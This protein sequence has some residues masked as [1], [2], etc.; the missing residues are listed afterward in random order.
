MPLWHWLNE[1]T[2]KYCIGKWWKV[3]GL[4]FLK[5]KNCWIQYK[6]RE[7]LQCL[8]GAKGR[9]LSENLIHPIPWMH[10]I[11][12]YVQSLI[13]IKK[14]KNRTN[15]TRFTLLLYVTQHQPP[16]THVQLCLSSTATCRLIVTVVYTRPH[17]FQH[18]KSLL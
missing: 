3:I 18:R 14:K 15:S 5:L 9:W 4:T 16:S 8:Y 10:Q 17:E 13:Y 11:M 7:A 12:S 6:L 2:Y 1:Q